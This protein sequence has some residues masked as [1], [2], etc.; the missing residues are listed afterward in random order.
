MLGIIYNSPKKDCNKDKVDLDRAAKD[1]A[2][3]TSEKKD[4]KISQGGK[5][6]PGLFFKQISCQHPY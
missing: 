1:I 5:P 6:H 2:K 3:I 4:E